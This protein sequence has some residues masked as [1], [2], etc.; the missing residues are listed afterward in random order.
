MPKIELLQDTLAGKPVERLPFSIWY[1][2]GTQHAAPEKTAQVHLEFFQAYD[3]DLLKVMNDYDYPM[4]EGLESIETPE[5]L[6]QIKILDIARTPME[7]QLRTIEIIAAT[8]GGKAF[9]FDTVFN[10]WNTMRRSLAKEFMPILMEK[11]PDALL[12]ALSVVNRNLIQYALT[13]LQLGSSGIFLSVPASAEFLTREQ[14]EKFMRPFDLEFLKAIAAEGKINI[15][16]AHGE[17]LYLD[18]LLDYP[19]Q[20]LS[21]ADLNG[22]PSIAEVRKL[23]SLTLMAGIDHIRFPYLSIKALRQQV[24]SAIAQAG[25]TKFILAGGCAL[26]TYSFA[27]LIRA[28]RAAARDPIII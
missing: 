22:G 11:Y 5:D 4:P 14:Y 15:L 6:R 7:K 17:K 27:S 3:L 23:T 9:F 16:H 8:L 10:A 20:I 24:K 26:P 28:A 18:R 19:V 12:E 21:W 2:F 25:N 13:S 1:H